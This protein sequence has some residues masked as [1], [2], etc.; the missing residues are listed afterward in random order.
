V[1]PALSIVVEWEN[2]QR[3]EL[4]RARRMLARLEEELRGLSPARPVELVFVAGAG[5][6][7]QNAAVQDLLGS[8]GA[9]TRFVEAPGAGYYEQKNLGAR[10]AAGDLIV[11]LDSDVVP[12]AGWL[13]ALLEPFADPGVQVVGGDSHIDTDSLWS[14][15]FALAWFFPLPSAQESVRRE[16]Q[17]FANNVAFRRETFLAQPFPRVS[18]TDRGAC[19]WLAG[20]LAERGVDIWRAPGARVRHPAPGT[21]RQAAVRAL[22]QGRDRAVLAR[23][24]GRPSS[25]PQ[26]SALGTLVSSFGSVV[27]KRRAVGLPAIQVP[28]ALGLAAAYYALVAAGMA[29]ARIAPRTARRLAL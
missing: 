22:V 27:R 8:P 7:E 14:K 4:G 16:R 24:P 13:S 9:A 10:E 6:A 21:V 26:T 25:A 17:F 19:V 28:L 12:E 23:E 29:L 5:G 2:V 18:G 15:T 3:A 11:F 20:M 1:R